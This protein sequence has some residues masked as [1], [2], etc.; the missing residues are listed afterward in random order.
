MELFDSYPEWRDDI[1]QR[2]HGAQCRTGYGAELQRLTGQTRCAYCGMDLVDTFDHW[3]LLTV[4]HVI[5]L[6]TA[7]GKS[8]KWKPWLASIHNLVIACSACNGFA[9]RFRPEVG[10]PPQT[11]D[12][13]RSV[14][15]R[16][17]VCRKRLVCERRGREHQSYGEKPWVAG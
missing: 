5:P 2:L 6:S 17:F 7:S 15:D 16:V 13:F 12:D 4:D 10:G 11:Y 8:A 14:R 3:L 9:N 1:P